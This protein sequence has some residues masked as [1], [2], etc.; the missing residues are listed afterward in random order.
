MSLKE[1]ILG[2]REKRPV[3]FQVSIVAAMITVAIL[4]FAVM[5]STREQVVRQKM[6]LPAPKVNVTTAQVGPTR[7]RITGE[8]TVSPLREIDLVPQV[9]GR[10]V[11]MSSAMVDGGMFSEG[12]V[13]LRIDP[14]D[15]KLAVKA[16][17]ARVKDF[18]SKLM[19]TEEEAE[20]AREEWKLQKGDNDDSSPPPLVA[21]E[22]QLAAA[23][24]ALAGAM[25]DLDK[26]KLNLKRTEIKAPFDGRISSKSVDLG[27]FIGVGQKLGAIFS[28]EA[29]EISVPLENVDLRWINV[30]GFT[31][32]DEI[33]SEAI[34]I[35]TIAGQDVQRPARLMRT[36]G[37]IDARTRM[38]NVIVR[39]DRPYDV[40]PPLAMGLFVR[41][42]FAGVTLSDAIWLPR[43]AIHDGDTVYIVDG[44]D[45]I[46]FTKVDIAR[47]DRDEVLVRSGLTSGELIVTSPMKIVTEGMKVT[48]DQPEVSG[49]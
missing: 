3:A 41:V 18:E 19:L 32:E 36:E 14:E 21:K 42:E 9:G 31:D 10:V 8:G 48:Y 4:I 30:P 29:A 2:F 1:K 33:T 12:E 24:A 34:V 16:A 49:G 11:Y 45:R 38:V 5:M 15:Y 25:A 22:P 6:T 35:A 20:A 40:R 43:S 47:Y 26:A 13:L 28:V 37:R 39:V 46:R 17:E 44:E 27:Q 7:V 23:R